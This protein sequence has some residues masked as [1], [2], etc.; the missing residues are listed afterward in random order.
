MAVFDKF[1][2]CRRKK[3]EKSKK[4]KYFDDEDSEFDV[5]VDIDTDNAIE[6]NDVVNNEAMEIDEI[7]PVFQQVIEQAKPRRRPPKVPKA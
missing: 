6:M 3:I 5:D 2:W 7:K 4:N 1:S